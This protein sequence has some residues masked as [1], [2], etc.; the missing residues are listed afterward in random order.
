MKVSF[1]KERMPRGEKSFLK[2]QERMGQAE[3]NDVSQELGQDG[4]GQNVISQN[5]DEND[6]SQVLKRSDP[7]NLQT[8][9]PN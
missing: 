1:P 2:N 4:I 6:I 9:L 5:Q 3:V 8:L 7:K